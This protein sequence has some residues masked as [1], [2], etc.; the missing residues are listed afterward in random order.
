MVCHASTASG[1]CS[2][3][4]CTSFSPECPKPS[5]EARASLGA[6]NR[7]SPRQKSLAG[8]P[9]TRLEHSPLF[10]HSQSPFHGQNPSTGFVGS[11]SQTMACLGDPMPLEP[12]TASSP[13]TSLSRVR[14]APPKAVKSLGA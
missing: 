3:A 13:V 2:F 1:Q 11:P 14:A 5:T 10:S 9:P 7:P 4:L 12:E 6:L 8:T